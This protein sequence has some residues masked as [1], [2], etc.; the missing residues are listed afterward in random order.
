MRIDQLAFRDT[1]S[2][3]TLAPI[4]FFPDLTLLVGVSG[5][6]KTRILQTIQMLRA[7]AEGRAFREI[8]GIEWAV[9]FATD[10]GDYRWAGEFEG[11]DSPVEE[12]VMTGDRDGLGN[13]FERASLPRIRREYVSKDGISLVERDTEKIHFKGQ[14][15]LKLPSYESVLCTL[16][17]EDDLRPAHEGF[18][19]TV[20]TDHLLASWGRFFPEFTDLCKRFPD[21]K[22]IRESNLPTYAKLAL[23]YENVPSVFR[24]IVHRY[25]DIF[26][27][28]EDIRFERVTLGSL[29]DYL[30]LRI[31]ERG[32][33]KWISEAKLSSG[34]FRT[35]IYL[36]NGFLW[37]DGTV[38]LIDE[39]ENSLGVNCIHSVTE[40]MIDESRRL[41]FIVTSHHPYIINNISA[42]HWKI[43]RRKGSVV[44]AHDA[45][46]L[47]IGRSRHE[48]FVQLLNSEQY[49]N[50]VA[51]E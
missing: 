21:L 6:G 2:D 11:R 26:P 51:V 50:G 44:T 5:V 29:R 47:G 17:E 23:V 40:D 27:H 8:W 7:I 46:E 34:M 49:Q 48:A 18:R 16:R 1:D 10:A 38:I 15:T 9:D 3:W 42:K 33:D 24:Q 31:K 20:F 45:E 14:P 22:S 19:R 25:I 35:L 39:F 4:K 28:V 37:P 36:S 12:T 13:N 30:D 41:Q 43:L 32:V